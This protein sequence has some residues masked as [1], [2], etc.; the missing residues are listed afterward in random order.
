MNIKKILL[1]LIIVIVLI[2]IFQNTPAVEA[3][4]LAWTVSMPKALLLI[5]TFFFG[6]LVGFMINTFKQ[7]K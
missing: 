3:T 5:I 2:F 1:A 6:I 4:F 7:K